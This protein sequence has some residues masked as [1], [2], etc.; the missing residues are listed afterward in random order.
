MGYQTI[1]E[2]QE[3]SQCCKYEPFLQN[4]LENELTQ[5]INDMEKISKHLIMNILI[6]VNICII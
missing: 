2:K 5:T 1:F 4:T 6:Y 3:I